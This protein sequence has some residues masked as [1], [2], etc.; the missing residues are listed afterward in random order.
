MRFR[1]DV[2][3]L[4]GKAMEMQNTTLAELSVGGKGTYG[5][6]APAVDYSD[7]KYTYL[8]IT[9]IRDDGTLNK[10][11]LK[12]VDDEKASQFLLKPNDIVFARTGQS[13]G[14]NYFYDGTDGEFVYAGFLIKFSIDPNKVNPQYIKYYCQ[15]D[16]YKGWLNSFNSGSTIGNINAKVLGAMPITL[17]S[18]KQQDGMVDIL[19]SL[20]EKKKNSITIKNKLLQQLDAIYNELYPYSTSDILPNGWESISV[21]SICDSVSI[22][23]SF[24]K[25]KL[26][27]LNTG[28]VEN[29]QILHSQYSPVDKM[30]GQAKKSIRQD[31]ILYSEIRPI[32][33]HFTY[34]SFP[35]DDFVVSTKLM[36]IRAR[37]FD[38]RRLYHF[39]TIQNTIDELQHEAEIRSGTFPQ[40]RFENIK[41]L[42]LI[43]APA[44]TEKLFTSLLHT[45][46]H[47]IDI[48]NEEVRSINLIK[49]VLIKQLI[50]GELDVSN[51]DC[52]KI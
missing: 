49:D 21:G 50:S 18:R 43:L 33:R 15:S 8:R 12:S 24:D 34:V 45:Y 51:L 9:D 44:E 17:P 7:K 14:R 11:D 26:I 20:D 38:S 28:D 19:S 42:S 31:D 2:Y 52:S 16:A 13:T 48:A 3:I 1:E 30:P 23:H 4:K 36:V 46:Y 47:A 10:E 37:G 25:K 29:G 27:F 41:K 35:S 5:I 40:I 6:A 39:L 22:T 32:N